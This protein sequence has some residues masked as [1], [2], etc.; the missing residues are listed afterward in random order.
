MMYR[1]PIT[2][3]NHRSWTVLHRQIARVIAPAYIGN[4]GEI[5]SFRDPTSELGRNTTPAEY[6]PAAAIIS[7]FRPALE[8][9]YVELDK[10]GRGTALNHDLYAYDPSQGVAVIQ[11]RQYYKHTAN[12]Y[13]ATRKTYFIC[14]RN[15]I[16]G[17]FFRHPVGSHAVRAA[18]KKSAE[19]TRADVVRAA[20]RWMWQVTEKQ[21]ARSVR[22]GDILLVPE[23]EPVSAKRRGMSFTV[24]G[25]HKIMADEIRLNGRWYGLN[26]TIIHA[27]DQHAP[28]E[29]LVGWYSIRPARTAHAWDFADRIG[30]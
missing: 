22:Q 23:H 14:G 29:N 16:T 17:E 15:E 4:W 20:Q 18:C 12:G 26:P 7:L 27:K 1:N 8:K 30:D 3:K 9:E 28:I 2:K 21:L 6:L 24:S 25:S 10:K 13:G 11:A 5:T 19:K